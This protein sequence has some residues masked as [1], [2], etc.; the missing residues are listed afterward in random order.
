MVNSDQNCCEIGEKWDGAACAAG[1]DHCIDHDGTD[2]LEC[3]EGY[4]VNA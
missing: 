1:I 4:Y 3:T 2:C